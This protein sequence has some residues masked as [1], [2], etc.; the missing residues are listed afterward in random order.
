MN[1]SHFFAMLSRMKYINRWGLMYNTYNEN[2]SEHS[3]QTAM[4]AHCMILMHNEKYSEKLNAERGALLAMYHD[5]SEIITGDLPT[6]VK[7]YNSEI[8]DAFKRVEMYAEERLVLLLP[9]NL[10]KYYSNILHYNESDKQL[11]VY[12]KAAD[13]ISAIT[14]CIEEIKIGNTEFTDAFKSLKEALDNMNLL[15]A[16]EFYREFVPSFKL[17]LDKLK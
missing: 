7:Y 3:L 5:T 13:K 14:K 10:R 1:T 6:P 11:W 16:N 15:V 17:T 2:I 4:F 12:V 9:E 8:A